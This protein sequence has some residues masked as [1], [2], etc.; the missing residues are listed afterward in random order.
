MPTLEKA[1]K[2][3][4]TVV[5]FGDAVHLIYGSDLG[6]SWCIERE[7]VKSSYGRKRFNIM[8]ALDSK[9]HEVITVSNDKYITST[10]IDELFA[11]LRA[12]NPRKRVFIFLNNA[13]YQKCGF[14]RLSSEKYKINIIYLPTCSPNLNLIKRLWKFLRKSCL[15]N[16]YF[17]TFRLFC[18]SLLNCLEMTHNE[19]FLVLETLLAHNFESLGLCQ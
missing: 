3:K 17:M 13:S 8:G 4:D 14:V 10:E 11:K 19:Y 6:Y 1:E 9:S 12:K 5:Y 16:K 18:D 7:Q 15:C 2:R